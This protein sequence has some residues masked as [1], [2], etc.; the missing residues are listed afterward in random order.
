MIVSSWLSQFRNRLHSR[1]SNHPRHSRQP[2]ETLEQRTYLTTSG[3][4]VGTELTLFADDGDNIAVQADVTTGTVVVLANGT[5]S[6]TVPSVQASAISGLR[7]RS[8]DESTSIDLSGVTA[9]DFSGLATTGSISVEA[10]DGDD[11]ITGSDDFAESLFGE[12][13]NDSII[14]GDGNDTID[15]GDGNDVLDGGLGSD[16]I[17][18][19]DGNDTIDGGDGDDNIMAQDGADVVSGGLGMDTI[20]AGQGNDNVDAG[21]GND[22]VNGMSGND[23]ITGGAGNDSVLAGSGNDAVNGNDGD[24]TLDGQGGQDTVFGDDGGDSIR[25]GSSN[26]SL[27]GGIGNDTVNGQGGRDTVV[28]NDDDDTLFGGGGADLLLGNTGNDVVRGQGGDDTIL[29]GGGTDTLDGGAG[30]DFVSSFL[31]E[32]DNSAS[33]AT[34]SV[35]DISVPEANGGA[36]TADFV[37]NLSNV[38]GG[39]VEIAFA[40]QDGT[41]TAGSD[42]VDFPGTVVFLPGENQKTVSVPILDDIAV[43][44]DET[45]TLTLSSP[46]TALLGTT[47]A[48]ATIVDNDATMPVSFPAP[49]L[50]TA[51]PEELMGITGTHKHEDDIAD[52][53]SHDDDVADDH[54]H[55]DFGDVIYDY[56]PALHDHGH[57]HSSDESDELIAA[58]FQAANRWTTTAT[59]GGGQGQGDTTIITWGIVPDGTTTQAGC[60]A[61]ANQGS[62]LIAIF[63]GIYNET[64]T[65]PDVTN[66]TW[67]T[68]FQSVFDRFEEVS[69]IDF[70]Y[71][72]NDDGIAISGANNGIVGTRADIRIV[73]HN[74]PAPVIG[75]NFF[76]N[77]GDMALATN[78]GFF[79][80]TSQ[81]SRGL[82]NTIGHE[83]GHGIGFGHTLPSDQTKLL[84]PGIT[85]AFDGPQFDDILGVQRQYGDV[86]E[87]GLGNDTSANATALGGV[88]FGQTLSIGTDALDTSVAFGETDFVSIDGASDT[89]FYGIVLPAGAIVDI[90]LT[91]VGPTYLEG[92]QGGPA[93]TPFDT[94]MLNDLTLEFLDTDGSTVLATS[95][96]GGTGVAE[97]VSALNLAVEGT[98]FVRVTGS[99]DSVQM[100]QLDVSVTANTTPVPPSGLADDLLGDSLTA[101]T[102]NDTVLGSNGDDTIN[103]SENDDSIV[104]FGGDDSINAGAGDDTIDGGAGDDTINGGSGNDVING[105]PGDDLVIWNGAGSGVDVIQESLG[106]Q[107]LQVQG[108]STANNLIVRSVDVGNETLLQVAEGVA[109]ITT[110]ATVGEVTVL[111]GGGDDTITVN[112]LEGIRPTY[113]LVDGQNDNDTITATNALLGRTILELRGGNDNDTIS[114]SR[115]ADEIFG[116]LGDDVLSGG[117]GND[118]IDGGSGLDTLNGD[119][120][121]DSLF[122][123]LNND[124]INGGDGDDSADGGF[125]HDNINGQNGSDT[126]D[127]GFGDDT[128]NGAAGNDLVQG[129]P[130]NDRI[131]GGAG[132]DSLDGSTGDDT[133]QGQSGSD[134]IKG[135]DGNDSI[136][137]QGG[138]D[139]IDAGDGED[140]VNA[141]NGNDIVDGGD[142]HDSINGMSGRD[143][144]IGGD[145]NDTLIGGGGVDRIYG[146]DGADTLRGNGSIDRFNSGEGGQVPDDL[147]AG[148]SDDQNLAIQL[149]VLEALAE[150]NGF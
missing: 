98:Y 99:I 114:G 118:S 107:S 11:T 86:N 116:D 57:D 68:H 111:G 39:T 103:G 92:P 136:L 112:T 120:G 76:P 53:H 79:N 31:G 126:L 131:L 14:G 8:G 54:S 148:E 108:N 122:G 94:S 145:G 35:S 2:I 23:T 44:G 140:T 59:T 150:L 52:G 106:T 19:D 45:F 138:N 37:I 18:G 110:S 1:F 135:G 27:V 22:T 101:S 28:G 69:G 67:F 34:V 7:V 146:G 30:D 117:D 60:G 46:A 74:I 78:S 149:S 50:L 62:N 66:R 119:G 139:T 26:D 40:T 64:A 33:S 129:G 42:Y 38:S 89:D 81:N 84:E 48:T 61:A 24:D 55:D 43:E 51:S 104:G 88:D 96:V 70:E 5:P 9:A 142:G 100:Y 77:H 147:G 143:T 115:D 95:N 65:G 13:G 36:T 47:Q 141:G 20:D 75:C 125:G 25:G 73:G 105:S 102:G 71:E 82:R 3:I 93:P 91:P 109:S 133:I 121:N 80:N 87:T 15:G 56:G 4:L 123:N 6:S 85:F 63:D 90:T 49:T 12:D 130:D 113:L 128:L 83:L 124:V 134:Q 41:A 16:V 29:G 10:G 127:G 72:P 137:G 17:E 32:N 144:L 132:T 97:S 58:P 21:D